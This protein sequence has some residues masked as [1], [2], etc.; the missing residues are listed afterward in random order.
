[1]RD[2]PS[3]SEDYLAVRRRL[4][5]HGD[6]KP[7]AASKMWWGR[8]HH[9]RRRL[10]PAANARF[11]AMSTRLDR[12]RLLSAKHNSLSGEVRV[13]AISE[14]RPAVVIRT[15]AHN[16]ANSVTVEDRRED[17]ETD[18]PAGGVHPP[19][20]TLVEGVLKRQP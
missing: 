4:G 11:A 20:R 13:V 9:S 1:M 14:R 6:N 8:P 18:V 15:A 7:Y 10:R 12:P 5:L 19:L 17:S 3:P 2:H 16:T